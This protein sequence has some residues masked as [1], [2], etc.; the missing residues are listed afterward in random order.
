MAN[1]NGKPIR[2]VLNGTSV[3]DTMHG[4]G[5]DDTLNGLGG[6]DSLCGDTGNDGL[7][8]GIG[9]DKAW[10][11]RGVDALFG[12]DGADQ[13]YGEAGNDY[14]AG[15]NGNDY[16]HGGSGKDRLRGEDG[17]DTLNG[18]PGDDD[19][20]GGAGNDTLI[21]E[22]SGPLRSGFGLF[23]GD[24]GTDTLLMKAGG[25]I[26]P[27]SDGVRSATVIV[28]VDYRAI[29]FNDRPD[30]RNASSAEL[31]VGTFSGVEKFAVSADTRIDYFGADLNAVV[32]GGDQHDNFFAGSGNETFNGGKG[33][34]QFYFYYYSIGGHG[35]GGVDHIV[36]F[37]KAEDVI[38]T[39][40]WED[41]QGDEIYSQHTTE[42]NGQTTITTTTF[43]GKLIHT[44]IIDAVDIPETVFKNGFDWDSFA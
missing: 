42:E 29:G 15:G 10:G 44:L 30:E 24:V 31:Y 20:H 19:L 12:G 23:D 41:S 9:S 37:N 2:D 22:A 6:N 4:N 26:I 13:L 18:G 38:V 1:F 39:T 25:A 40:L 7:Y 8:G 43:D 3:A 27:T 16:L 33:A 21:Y 35:S 11:G 5:G 28:S 36:G 32:T 17:D 14:L 34:D